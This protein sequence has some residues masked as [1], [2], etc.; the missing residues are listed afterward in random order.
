MNLLTA[1]ARL[2]SFVREVGGANRGLWVSMFQ[3]YTGN[4]PGDS[5]C[6]SFVSYLLALKYNGKSPLTKTASCAAMLAQ[7]RTLGMEKALPIPGDLFFYV[8]DAGH[9]HHVGIITQTMPLTG[10]A[11]NTSEDGQS[12][13]GDGVYEHA[14]NVPS[15]HITY[16]RL[17]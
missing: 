3:Q 4:A 2:F 10:I 11:G 13:N 12:S 6:C 7:A 17:P 5:W 15:K 8:N 16:V 1:I 14:L 9:A